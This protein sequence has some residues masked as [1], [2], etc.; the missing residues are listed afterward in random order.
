M[1]TPTH[2]RDTGRTRTAV[3]PHPR[4]PSEPPVPAVQERPAAQTQPDAGE[5]IGLFGRYA[6]LTAAAG[7]ACVI[8]I[9]VAMVLLTWA[10]GG[11]T[12]FDR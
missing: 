12:P 2:A 1:S 8:A 5:P 7:I 4:P 10:A 6:W 9:F 3:V 11:M